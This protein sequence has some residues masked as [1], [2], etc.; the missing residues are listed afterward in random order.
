MMS[1]CFADS[2]MRSS[3]VRDAQPRTMSKTIQHL[4]DQYGSVENYIR[5]IGISDQE[6][7]QLR[8]GLC[9]PGTAPLRSTPV[10]N[11]DDIKGVSFQPR[12]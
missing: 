1:G 9:K 4:K 10:E 6:I 5:E 12:N 11:R 3:G 7:T 2:F 8:D